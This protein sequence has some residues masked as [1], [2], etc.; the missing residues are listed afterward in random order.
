MP[1]SDTHPEWMKDAGTDPGR[2]PGKAEG[3][4][5]EPPSR[6]PVEEPG[7]TGGKAEGEEPRE[8]SPLR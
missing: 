3:G 5:D 6:G 7:R 1:R 2:T 8:Q 4:V